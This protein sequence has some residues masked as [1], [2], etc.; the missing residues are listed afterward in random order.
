VVIVGDLS[1]GINDAFTHDTLWIR[2][3]ATGTN[4][5]A[6]PLVGQMALTALQLR[7]VMQDKIF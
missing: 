7:V 2:I 3:A 1:S 5:N 6:G 4:P